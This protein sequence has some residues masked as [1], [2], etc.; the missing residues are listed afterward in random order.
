MVQRFGV[1]RTDNRGQN[2]ED[3]G[4]MTEIGNRKSEGGMRKSE[5]GR[6]KSKFE[7]CSSEKINQFY[8]LYLRSYTI[9]LMPC[10]YNLT[11]GICNLFSVTSDVLLYALC[12]L[13]YALFARNS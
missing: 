1:Q 9:Q 10:P 3:S 5:V 13:L 11:S 4:Q 6:K 7:T 8:T 12:P 2:T